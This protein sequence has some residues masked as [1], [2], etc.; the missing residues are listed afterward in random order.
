MLVNKVYFYRVRTLLVAYFEKECIVIVIKVH[1][2]ILK[3]FDFHL[4]KAMT[5][6]IGNWWQSV[7]EFLQLGC[8]FLEGKCHRDWVF[9]FW[10]SVDQ[11]L[12]TLVDANIN[13]KDV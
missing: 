13:Q 3:P 6:N 12:Q 10:W 4:F 11:V 1:E 7:I 8:S 5:F 9:E 2:F